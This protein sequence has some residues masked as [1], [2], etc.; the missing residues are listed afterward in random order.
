MREL[1]SGT[2]TFLF[3]DIEGSTRLLE[4]LGDA[5][6]EVLEEHRRALRSAFEEPGGVEVDT[7]GDAFFV[8]FERAK[9]ALAAAAEA[10]RALSSGPVRVRMGVFTGEP[11]RTGEGYAG[12]DVHRASRMAAAGHGG[13]VLVSESSRRLVADDLATEYAL[14]D[15]GEHRLKDLS[16]PQRIFQLAAEGLQRDFPPLRTLE[17]RPTNLPAQPTPLVG[18][19]RELAELSELLRQPDVRVL[20]VTGPGGAGKTRLALQTAADL[21]ED[22]RDGTF[23]V[24]LAGATEPS[25]VVPMIARAIGLQETGGLS[26]AEVAAEYLRNRELLLVLDNFEHVLEAAP[27]V[28]DLIREASSVKA[29]CSSRA[30][31]RLSGEHEYAV[32]E[33]AAEDAVVLFAERAKAIDGEFRLNGDAPVVA[34]ICRRL[35]GLPLAIELAAA[36]TKVLSPQAMLGRLDRRLPLL[37]GGARDLPDRQRTLRDT[38]G[39]SYELLDEREQAAFASLAVFA[40]GFT[41]DAAERVCR[42]DLDTLASLAEKSLV[43]RREDR[44]RMLETI[45]EYALEQ[46]GERG[47]LDELRRRHAD[48]F[49]ELAESAGEAPSEKEAWLDRVEGELDNLRSAIA[50]AQESGDREL[51]LR[52][53]AAL[54]PFWE[55]RSYLA[56]GLARISEAL[57]TDPDSPVTLTNRALSY[58]VLLAFKQGDFATARGWAEQQAALAQDSGHEETFAHALNS[59]GIILTG[60]RR[61]GE[62]RS[63]LERSLAISERLGNRTRVQVSLH[64]LALIDV[65]E[66]AYESAVEKLTAAMEISEALGNERHAS[67]DQCDRAFA[68]I[69]LGRWR[70]AGIDAYESLLVAGRLGWRENVAYSLV[71][72]AAVAAAA[73]EVER[74]ARFLG[75]AD[76]LAEEVR[77]EF[78]G[79]AEQVRVDTPRGLASRHVREPA[80]SPAGRRPSVV[81]RRG[82]R[83]GIARIGAAVGLLPSGTVT[84]LFTDIEGSTRLLQELGDRYPEALA[85]HR[86]VLR[87]AFERHGGVEVDT[88]GDAFF[89][90]FAEARDAL[91]AAEEGQRGLRGAQSVFA[92]VSTPASHTLPRR[93]TSGWTCTVPRGSVP[94]DTAD[95]SSCRTRPEP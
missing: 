65:D 51:F 93:A 8:V 10:Q 81:S 6:R 24:Q 61:F 78:A 33:L 37:T 83:R 40:G 19:H 36:R 85:E 43:R 29:I 9:D 95:R 91:A 1:P 28:G 55:A 77:L 53:A 57:A 58:G 54:G 38:I 11:I 62:A 67:N 92:W 26:S 73:D 90:A 14:L 48:F 31:L 21:I 82:G 60:E 17:N 27:V 76:R 7:Q 68:L 70:E 15:L 86:R 46:L 66:G 25:L 80:R 52:L 35:D 72:L 2:V 12:M 64:N 74:A 84:F 88:Q 69:C 79:Y 71:A 34:E 44:F 63:V 59:L 16:A 18:R 89:V 30:A 47:D 39:W 50:W 75:Q 22:F 32:P 41:L 56:E 49:L 94:P 20:T 4:E 42:A 13:Q 45:R 87:E 3:T 23:F 5:Y